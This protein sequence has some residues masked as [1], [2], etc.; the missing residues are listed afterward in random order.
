[1]LGVAHMVGSRSIFFCGSRGRSSAVAVAAAYFCYVLGEGLV[2]SGNPL[3]IRS[4]GL[5]IEI[6]AIF[7]RLGGE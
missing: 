2:I 1:M 7:D 5:E 4:Q 3:C 6:S